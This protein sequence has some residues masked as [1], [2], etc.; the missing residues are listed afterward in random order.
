MPQSSE[1]RQ[2]HRAPIELRVEYQRLNR[3]FDDYTRNISM[4][5][6]FIKT[7]KPLEVGTEF[8]FKLII[9]ALPEPLVLRGDVRWI[10]REGETR[11]GEGPDGSNGPGMGIRFIYDNDEQR[12][13]VEREVETLMVRSL[14]PK[15]FASL[16]RKH[17]EKT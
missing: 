6:T 5:G 9:P 1:G 17:D 3:F 2:Q 13:E 11:A 7:S 8:I 4:G 16:R 10:L 12:A 15:I 14:G